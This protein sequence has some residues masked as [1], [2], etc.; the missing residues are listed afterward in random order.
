[1][2]ITQQ[3]KLYQRYES[4]LREIANML[5]GGDPDAAQ[6]AQETLDA[7][8]KIVNSAY[9]I[10]RTVGSDAPPYDRLIW[11]FYQRI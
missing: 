10:A 5:H 7:I 6:T 4:A 1:M 9:P 8:E 3:V 11:S 2:D